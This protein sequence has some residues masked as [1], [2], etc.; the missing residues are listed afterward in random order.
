M[1]RQP[2]IAVLGHVDHGKTSLLDRIR[3]TTIAA[4]EAGGITQA[5]GTTEIPASAVKE[6]CDSI[7]KKFRFD[8]TVPG[9]LFIDTPGH[10]AFSTLRH[11]GGA[12][13]DLA[14]LVVDIME[15]IMPQ[16]KESI[17]ILKE[18]KTPFVVAV[19]KI[20]RIPGWKMENAEFLQDYNLQSSEAQGEF[21][22][23]FYKLVEQFDAFSIPVER[24]D[25]ITDFT[26]KVAGVPMSTKTGEGIAEFLA[27]LIGLAQQFLK[28]E[29]VK[30]DHS[31]GMVLEVKEFTGMGTTLDAIIYDGEIS[32]NDFLIISNPPMIAKVR[33]LMIPQPMRD[34]RTEKKFLQVDNAVA[35]AGVKISGA[36]LD[37][38]IAGAEIRTAKNMADAEKMLNELEQAREE[39]E[40]R[41]EA[42]GLVLKADTLGSLEALKKIFCAHP[43]RSATIGRI[44]KRDIMEAEA[45]PENIHKVV[46]GFNISISPENELMAKNNKIKIIRSD[47]IYKLIEDYEKWLE[48]EKE[49]IKKKEIDSLPRPAVIRIL[50]GCVFRASNP[51][52]VGCEVSEGLIKP[53]VD[54]MKED[55]K[56]VGQVKQIQSQGINVESAKTAEKIAISISSA[57]VG[58]QIKEGDVLYTH[59]KSN[60]YVKLMKNAEFLSG[61]EKSALE[62]IFEIEKLNDSKYGM[63]SAIF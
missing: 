43:I 56:V 17:E 39:V 7:L 11:R 22:T 32:R 38:V 29:L 47:V 13:A 54:L 62:K 35:A 2:I 4:K 61:S 5:I 52:I 16:T 8:L 42:D 41:V 49:A 45:S 18:S 53:D 50:P 20:D 60:V 46:V 3:Q 27:I 59:I 33:S 19:N 28:K 51:A 57:A 23:Y 26:K 21:E 31:A 44:S 63:Q 25:R 37:D 58:R 14:V 30:T 9:L 6:I 36:G 48:E 10:E 40:V 34:I 55:G 1:L 24:F 12:I 15:G